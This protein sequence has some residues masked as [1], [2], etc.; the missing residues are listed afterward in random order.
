[1]HIIAETGATYGLSFNWA[2]VK[3]LRINSE[4]DIY[5]PGGAKVAVVDRL[6]YLGAI[7]HKDARHSTEMSHLCG[8]SDPLNRAS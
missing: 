1:M 6:L 2:K 4:D 8:A 7:L 3:L 5:A